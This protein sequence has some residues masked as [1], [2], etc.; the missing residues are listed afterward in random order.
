[1]SEQNVA[2]EVD[3]EVTLEGGFNPAASAWGAA[4]VLHPHPLYGGSMHNNVVLALVRAAQAGGLSALRINFRG[5]GRSTGRHEDGIGEQADVL[6]A[7]AWLGREAPGPLVLMGYSF[8]ALVG[9]RAANRTP[10]LAGGVWVSP[11]LVLGELPPWPAQAGPL[12]IVTGDRDEFTDVSRLRSYAA[13]QGALISLKLH[14]GGDHF[15]WGGESALNKEV[16]PFILEIGR[17]FGAGG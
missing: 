1:M 3:R 13:A 9:A 5:T 7:A 8:G 4:L 14:Q 11:P 16:A 17:T 12:L 2:I 10:G 15:W 6:A